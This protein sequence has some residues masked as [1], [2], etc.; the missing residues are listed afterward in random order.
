MLDLIFIT[1]DFLFDQMLHK[2]EPLFQELAQGLLP[3]I[4]EFF[5]ELK[6]VE[7]KEIYPG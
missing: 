4:K 6:V 3:S 2:K 5:L 1:S 7:P